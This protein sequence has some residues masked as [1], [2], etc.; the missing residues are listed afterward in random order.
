LEVFTNQKEL[1]AGNLSVAAG[2]TALK[3]HELNTDPIQL[4]IAFNRK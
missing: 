3:R 2:E 4:N 1:K